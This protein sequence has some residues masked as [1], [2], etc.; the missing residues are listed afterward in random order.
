MRLFSDS[1]IR[2][3]EVTE[4]TEAGIRNI[5]SL[6]PLSA[7]V[8]VLYGRG[9]SGAKVSELDNRIKTKFL[10]NKPLIEFIL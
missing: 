9:E 6:C 5:Q 7:C 4:D 2:S 1:S 8:C 10:R 3:C